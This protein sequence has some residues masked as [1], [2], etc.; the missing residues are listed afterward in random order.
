MDSLR[1]L[2]A[3]S[4]VA[5]LKKVG[6]STVPRKKD[7]MGNDLCIIEIGAHRVC[8]CE[9][10]MRACNQSSRSYAGSGAV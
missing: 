3:T 2:T 1:Q 6:G 5:R 7:A 9:D 8:V 4:G 10:Y